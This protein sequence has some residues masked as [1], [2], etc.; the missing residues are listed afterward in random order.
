MP[1]VVPTTTAAMAALESATCVRLHDVAPEHTSAANTDFRGAV[2]QSDADA[3][4][5][6]QMRLNLSCRGQEPAYYYLGSDFR[7]NAGLSY[8]LSYMAQMGRSE[9]PGVG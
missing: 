2:K 5:E 8:T 7:G 6:E 4:L 1:T 3:F 9:E